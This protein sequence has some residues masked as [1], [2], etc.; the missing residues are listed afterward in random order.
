MPS[1]P[2]CEDAAR[3]LRLRS[4]L[5]RVPAA[6]TRQTQIMKELSGRALIS[7]GGWHRR[8]ARVLLVQQ[9]GDEAIVL[10]DGNGDGAEV[11]AENWY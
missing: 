9:L 11:E 8:Y 1:S 6:P 4:G 7:A 2:V 3:G 10:V 5:Q